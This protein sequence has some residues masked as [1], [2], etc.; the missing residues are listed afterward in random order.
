MTNRYIIEPLPDDQW[1]A[2]IENRP[3]LGADISNTP[4]G[5]LRKFNSRLYWEAHEKRRI[6]ERERKAAF[7]SMRRHFRA[8]IGVPM[9]MPRWIWKKSPRLT[10][11]A[12][13]HY[14][15]VQSVARELDDRPTKAT[16]AELAQL[17][18]TRWTTCSA[19]APE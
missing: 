7:L 4:A 15:L 14:E 16:W 13:S 8:S 5:A 19:P 11:L 2:L 18:N 1:L 17:V 10:A 12:D 9:W 6:A 3:D